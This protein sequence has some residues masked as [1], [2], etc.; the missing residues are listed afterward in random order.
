MKRFV[1][2]AF[3]LSS[4]CAFAGQQDKLDIGDPAP[5]LKPSKW[6]KGK[7]VARFEK[8]KVY[9]VEFWATWC[10][11]CKEAMPHLS[12]LA[13]SHEGAV[14]FIG[15][16]AFEPK[17]LAKVA[18]FVKKQG[19]RM[20][21]RVAADG[22]GDK[23]WGD[24]MIAAGETGIPVSFVI[25]KDGRVAWIG[26]PAGLDRVLP[27]VIA[28]TLDVASEKAERA[29]HRDPGSA[30]EIA[31][32]KG[33]YTKVVELVDAY[34]TQHPGTGDFCPMQLYTSLARIDVA[35]L[36]KH[37]ADD[38]KRTHDDFGTY[39][40]LTFILSMG[41]FS[42]EAYRFGIETVEQALTKYDQRVLLLARGAQ[43]AGKARDWAKATDLQ[44]RAIAAAEADPSCPAERLTELR[45]DLEAFKTQK[46][47]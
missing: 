21:Y 22:P 9:V 29:A 28:G 12:E 8:G 27:Q 17:E 1:I 47:G 4:I 42:A 43:M 44:T 40:S 6:L 3:L 34:I 16:D 5:A 26:Q 11:P 15:V 36:R 23:T 10:T 32:G 38:L 35:K 20:D 7:P 41:E 14:E 46:G 31:L 19:A 30:V 33:Q 24:W 2:F 13:R 18:D 45:K 39:N 25:G 37:F